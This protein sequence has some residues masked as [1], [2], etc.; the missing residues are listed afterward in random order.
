[1]SPLSLHSSCGRATL[2]AAPPHLLLSGDKRVLIQSCCAKRVCWAHC[3]VIVAPRPSSVVTH[4]GDSSSHLRSAKHDKA[5]L[6]G[7]RRR[8]DC[9]PSR[10]GPQ[11]VRY[12]GFPAGN[13]ERPRTPNRD[14]QPDATGPMRS[15]SRSR[16]RN[17]NKQKRRGRTDSAAERGGLGKER[18]I[19]GMPVTATNRVRLALHSHSEGPK[20]RQAEAIAKEAWRRIVGVPDGQSHAR[21]SS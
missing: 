20:C 1:M 17:R 7:P 5:L 19:A 21:T 16:S 18:Q 11:I 14:Q 8:N 10:L 6:C 2:L 9:G 3:L 4:H 15:R 12:G 13:V